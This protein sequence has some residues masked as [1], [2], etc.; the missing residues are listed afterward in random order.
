MGLPER[1]ARG[2][3]LGQYAGSLP[4]QALNWKSVPSSGRPLGV[5]QHVACE[6]KGDAAWVSGLQRMLRGRRKW[7]NFSRD[8]RGRRMSDTAHLS[9]TAAQQLTGARQRHGR[10]ASTCLLTVILARAPYA[11]RS[12]TTAI[13]S[14]AP[15]WS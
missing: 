5:R 9:D 15:R 7:L 11:R 8:L 1:P 10:K 2:S 6:R 13:L 12:W 4:H 14:N 3:R